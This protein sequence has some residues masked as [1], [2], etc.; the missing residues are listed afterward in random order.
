MLVRAQKGD[1]LDSICQRYYGRTARVTE[2]ALEANP[3]LADLGPTIPQ[4]T[5]VNL[6]EFAPPET[7]TLIQLWD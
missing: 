3:G 6:P 1:T 2:N 4:G 7:K 5:P